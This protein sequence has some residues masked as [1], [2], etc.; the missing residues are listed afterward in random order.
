MSTNYPGALDSYADKV[1]GVDTVSAA[2]VNDLQDA[3]EAIETALGTNPASGFT[4]VGAGLAAKLS[5]SGGT[6]TGNLDMGANRVTNLAAPED[7]NDAATLLFVEDMVSP[8]G[9]RWRDDFLGNRSSRWTVSGTGGSY[10]QNSEVGGTGDLTTG[11][12]TSNTA[13]LSFNGKGCTS[14]AKAPSLFVRAKL[15]MAT[16]V[17]AVLAGLFNDANNLIEIFYDET[18]PPG[19]FKY[20]CVSGGTQTVVDS[21]RAADTSYHLFGIE[22]DED[23]GDVHFS[24]DDLNQETISTNIPTAV[25]EPRIGIETKENSDKRLTVDLL[26]LE[27]GR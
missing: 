11:A 20:R 15:S 16:Q 6:M 24:I 2:H 26:H 3:V 8:E 25:L 23:T 17:K 7:D 18:S 10:A 9:I 4:S 21:G 19:N 22:V 27:S 13:Y 1:D 5:K 12:T 14:E